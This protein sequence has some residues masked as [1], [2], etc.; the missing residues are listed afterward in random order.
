MNLSHAGTNELYC[1]VIYLQQC[2]QPC[3][4]PANLGLFFY[5]LVG[6]FKDLRIA[7]FCVCVSQISVFLI[8]CFRNFTENFL[9]QLTVKRNVAMFLCK[10]AY[11]GFV[12]FRFAC[13]FVLNLLLFSFCSI[14]I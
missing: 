9:F 1:Y 5:E 7:C 2:F 11:F 4:F 6:Y 10:F 12:F 14:F 3:G 8:A 13:F